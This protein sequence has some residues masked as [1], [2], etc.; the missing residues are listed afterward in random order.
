MAGFKLVGGFPESFVIEAPVSAGVA[1]A[2]GDL[3][4]IS[5]NVLARATSSS[6][7]HTIFAVATETITTADTAIK[8]RPVCQGQ[9]YEGAMTNNTH[10][11]NQTFESYALTDHANVANDSTDV[12]GP[13]GV[14]L[15]I[16]PIG[17][18]SDK[19]AL[20]EFTR[21]QSTST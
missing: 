19:R 16:A 14:F 7:I 5:G 12:T 9:L 21:L 13:T 8:C 15:L 6:T 20:G 18:V 17:A 3:L 11:S 4:A 10:A 2:E 1:I